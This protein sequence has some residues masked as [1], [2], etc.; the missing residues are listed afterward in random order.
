MS[1]LISLQV[2]SWNFKILTFH[3]KENT[4]KGHVVQKEELAK[5]NI[6]SQLQDD[7]KKAREIKRMNQL[8]LVLKN[9]IPDIRQAILELD[10][11]RSGYVNHF[12]FEQALQRLRINQNIISSQ[13]IADVF[14][15]FKTD[16]TKLNYR[17]F[18]E[19]LQEYT[20]D[21]DKEYIDLAITPKK[22][23][24]A[25]LSPEDFM[26]KTLDIVDCRNLPLNMIENYY[27]RSKKVGRAI[28]QFLP[29]KEA[30]NEY[31]SKRLNIQDAENGYVSMKEF[32][33]LVKDMFNKFEVKHI[34]QRDL[35]GF[36][37][38]ILYNKHGMTTMK[39]VG[40]TIYE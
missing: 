2:S 32:K 10:R 8:K 17:D 36:L 20:F 7:A 29:N 4:N 12:K 15:K 23:K 28:Q 39:E 18:L 27:A 34:D 37:S 25:N 5:T 22:K 9:R 38:S 16:S 19:H 14:E 35:E 3:P 6:I 13:D 40:H 24:H 1:T 30:L 31:V 33:G 11:D 26:P 21:Y